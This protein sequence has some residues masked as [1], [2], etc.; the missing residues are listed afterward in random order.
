[1]DG[2]RLGAFLRVAPTCTGSTS[3]QSL[4][5][6]WQ[7]TAATD[8]VVVI[9]NGDRHPVGVVQ[10]WHLA[11]SLST[12][13]ALGD[14]GVEDMM[15]PWRSPLI[16]LSM[17][18]TIDQFQEWLLRLGQPMPPHIALV[19]P[20]QEYVGLLDY[21]AVIHHLMTAAPMKT[22]TL[23]L[24]LS[25]LLEHLPLPLCLQN[26][27]GDILW[28]NSVWQDNLGDV[29]WLDR[30]TQPGELYYSCQDIFGHF[31]TRAD[32]RE[33]SR[34]TSVWRVC[35]LPV[36]AMILDP[37]A[38]LLDSLELETTASELSE[39]THL[40]RSPISTRTDTPIY[41]F[42][43]GQ[44]VPWGE[45]DIDEPC[46][47][48]GLPSQIKELQQR[49]LQQKNF[50]LG[51]GHELKNPLTSLLGL[52]Q[53][54]W[55]E[56]P[57]NQ[58]TYLQLIEQS[59]WQL[60]RL[61]HDWLDL[62]RA[63]AGELELVWE[64]IAVGELWH[65]AFDLAEQLYQ[66]ESSAQSW[67]HRWQIEPH[68]SI[69]DVFADSLRLRQVL[70]HVIGWMFRSG[71][72]LQAA[73]G[74]IESWQD[75][76]AIHLWEQGQGIPHQQQPFLFQQ[77]Q[78]DRSEVSVGLVLARQLARLHGGELSFISRPGQGSEWTVL[79]PAVS[80]LSGLG[81][82]SLVLI[83]GTQADWL[84]S[85]SHQLK[86]QGYGSLIA[87]HPLEALEKL[88]QMNP[89]AIL[90]QPSVFL[91]LSE[92]ADLLSHDLTTHPKP[93]LI[94]SPEPLS[95]PL[96]GLSRWFEPETSAAEIAQYLRQLQPD[97]N[98]GTPAKAIPRDESD[99][100]P[101][102]RT[103]TVLRLGLMQ[104]LPLQFCRVLEAEDIEQAQLLAQIWRPDVIL[105]DMP[106][107]I[108]EVE[109]LAQYESLLALP[110]VTLDT[111]VSR[112]ASHVS[113]LKVFPCLEL[114][115]LPQVLTLAGRLT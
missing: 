99:N 101:I 47:E 85:M 48:E 45:K 114:S 51:L 20:Q 86:D 113:G 109:R 100:N 21:G 31:H 27:R 53:M 69:T 64:S 89:L 42:L 29:A 81:T 66:R 92:L 72:S 111:S 67:F 37:L 110:L 44:A 91:P 62:T 35:G 6:A 10:G 84:S 41:W 19:N 83:L 11:V 74:R 40:G 4:L 36:S 39:L 96:P 68:P 2:I 65:R 98:I 3:L 56:K 9:V 15:G 34:Q 80:D 70:A 50:L 46:P 97:G 7:L 14:M 17:D 16:C 93:F 1:M 107:A 38:P 61:I 115:L 95:L 33:T 23:E 8:V 82:C 108:A 28:Q 25:E 13:P 54:L 59:S 106:T 75:W 73:G 71:A 63:E 104:D 22:P 32:T 77:C 76:I 18:C 112:A 60:N 26:Q 52:T 24:S 78:L 57:S 94:F 49:R 12:E 87:R 88:R 105:W 5:S 55:R 79:L 102:P 30:S 90:V 43:Y 103:L 58:E